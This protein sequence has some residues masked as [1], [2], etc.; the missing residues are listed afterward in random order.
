MSLLKGSRF[1]D[2]LKA[3]G[4]CS[5]SDHVRRVVIEATA[6]DV[7]TI[8]IERYGDERML[9]VGRPDLSGV[10]VEWSS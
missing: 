1:I 4:I 6:D 9:T 5:E 3:A 10:K 8:Y 2:W 7:V